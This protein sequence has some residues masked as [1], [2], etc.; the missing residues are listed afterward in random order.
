MVCTFDQLY[1][2]MNVWYV[3]RT[4]MLHSV[5]SARKLGI[6]FFKYLSIIGMNKHYYQFLANYCILIIML[7]G[8]LT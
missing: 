8:L 3:L 5:M 6:Y 1:N 2:I 4:M 7:F